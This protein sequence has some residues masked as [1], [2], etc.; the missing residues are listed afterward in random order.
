VTSLAII[1][2]S[3]AVLAAVAYAIVQVFLTPRDRAEP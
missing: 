1:V 3:L 2:I